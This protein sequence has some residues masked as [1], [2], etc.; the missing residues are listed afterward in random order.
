[1]KKAWLAIANKR[2]ASE[3]AVKKESQKVVEKKA[4]KWQK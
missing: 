1:M 2:Y 3:A 4:R